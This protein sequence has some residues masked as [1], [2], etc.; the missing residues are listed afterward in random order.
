MEGIPISS[1]ATFARDFL[2]SWRTIADGVTPKV[3]KTREKYWKAWATYATACKTDPFL[4]HTDNL[5]RDLVVNAFAARVRAGTYGRG[6]QIRVQGVS[7]ALSAISKTIQLAGKHSPIYRE[8]GKSYNLS[9][10]RLLEG[11][12]REDPPAV[13]QL[14]VPIS[15]PNQCYK[16]AMQSS[17]PKEEATGQLIIIAFYY[18]LRVGEYTKPRYVTRGGKRIRATRTKQF[19]VGNIGFFKN[20]KIIPRSSPLEVLL[21]C[22]SATLKISNQKNGRMGDTIHQEAV[23]D[24]PACPVKALAYRVHHILSHG[25]NNDN[26]LCDY[27]NN[28][29]CDSITSNDIILAIRHAGKVLKLHEQ[30]IDTDLIGAHSLRAGGAMA[31]K[32]S[33]ASDTIIMKVGRWRSLTFT[34]YIHNQIAHLSKDISKKM[35][36]PMPFLNIARVEMAA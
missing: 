19:S 22:D 31:L 35:S 6:S 12:R 28:D 11:Y 25:G 9:T 21:S 1:K 33:G 4:E 5:R 24:A 13:P 2:S 10:A 15:V 18:L 30:A 32:L 26:L 7:D 3:T 20:G 27:F 34:Q 23:P 8:D 36:I 29:E 14:A 17:S 16:L